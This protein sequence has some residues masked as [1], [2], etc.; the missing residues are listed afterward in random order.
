MIK[1][2]HTSDLHL[3]AKL[4]F[5]DEKANK[6]RK[7]LRSSFSEIIK[8][9]I[10]HKYNLVCITGDLFDTTYPNNVD[11]SFVIEQVKLLIAEGIYCAIIP[12]NHDRLRNGSVYLSREFV[13]L[14]SENL[15]IFTSNN[16]TEWQI[17]DLDLTVYANPT[18]LQ[19]SKQSPLEGLRKNKETKHHIGLAHG[20]LSIQGQTDNYPF[21]QEEINQL[22]F[23]YLALGDWHSCKEISKSPV[24]WYS[25]S[26]E[27]IGIN[28]TGSGFYLEVT[29]DNEVKV[30]PISIGKYSVKELEID[31]STVNSLGEILEQV[32]K[33][34][35]PDVFLKL[36]LTGFR[37][38]GFSLDLDELTEI[39]E[40]KF[41]YSKIYDKSNLLI[42]DDELKKFPEEF[43][44]GKFIRLMQKTKKSNE[45]K[46]HNRK[47]DEAIQ[48]GIR[49]L[50]EV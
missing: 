1:V 22:D 43:V 37:K 20:S 31:L 19:K 4:S 24:A 30:R 28:Q 16:Q 33:V 11:K 7:Q 40:A 47:I 36:T 18:F 5:L 17:K 42:S 39:V 23:D 8:S 44:M 41:Y 46:E 13:A 3:G 14:Q 50:R 35:S 12:G 26:P 27:L 45:D 21:T 38:V 15:H 6:H 25:G 34:A 2:L 9:A 48:L 29:I 32:D 49:L 10:E